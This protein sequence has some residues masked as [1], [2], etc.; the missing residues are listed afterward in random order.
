VKGSLAG[1]PV[2][3]E[4]WQ[5]ED[6]ELKLELDPLTGLRV[7]RDITEMR[8]KK[9]SKSLDAALLGF[10]CLSP[11]DAE[12][13]AE[14]FSAAG[15]KD[16]AKVVHDVARTMINPESRSHSPPLAGMFRQYRDLIKGPNDAT[17]RPVAHNSDLVEG[18]NAHYVSC[19]EYAVHKTSDL[20]DN[21]YSGMVSREQPLMFTISTVGADL[22]RPLYELERVA[23]TLPDVS[24]PTPY[25]TVAR[26]RSAG[27][28]FIKYG[29]DKDDTSSDLEDPAVINGCNPASWITPEE[30][31][32]RLRRPGAREADIRRKHFNQ[33]MEA[34][35][36]GVD[37]EVW[38]A[39]ARPGLTIPQGADT[40][41]GIDVGIRSDWTAIVAAHKDQRGKILLEAYLF[42]PPGGGHEL[43]LG[44]VDHTVDQ[45]SRRLNVTALVLDPMYLVDLR[46]RWQ[47]RGMNV[48]EF[49][50]Y[51]SRL[52]PASLSF[53]EA[54]HADRIR[55]NGDQVLRQHVLNAQMMDAPRGWCYE[56]PKN[57]SAKID[58]LIGII[59]ATHVV[60]ADDAGSVYENRGFTIL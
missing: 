37:P 46:Q 50:Q 40:V 8:P 24:K 1:Q 6:W 25:K 16:Q 5:Y 7:F 59:M 15:G 43:D 23:M 39:S 29:L 60:L 12:R 34:S 55:H 4:P 2:E 18:A 10:F 11:F 33:W 54:L 14:G 47:G 36:E 21:L 45:L 51:R 28:L 44:I 48:V 41:I 17:W 13:G 42:E 58:G 57:S 3:F 32:R 26:D 35:S 9:G 30:I 22:S 52:A 56:K 49:P 19:D 27:F 53:H 31:V 38:D 20:R